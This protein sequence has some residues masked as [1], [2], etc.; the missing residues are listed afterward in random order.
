MSNFIKQFCQTENTEY[1]SGISTHEK[2]VLID[3]AFR[4]LIEKR[5]KQDLA[6]KILKYYNLI[7]TVDEKYITTK[8]D[9]KTKQDI[10]VLRT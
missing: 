9:R 1:L 7:Q 8:R 4:S 2:E 10:E 3:I 5:G 6:E